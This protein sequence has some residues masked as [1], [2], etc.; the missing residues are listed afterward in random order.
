MAIDPNTVWEVRTG[1]AQSN[2]A[3]FRWV[4]LVNATYRWILSAAGVNEY[5]CELAAGGDPTLV[6]PGSLMLDGKFNLA[7]EGV[8]G[9]LA[10][11][12]WGYGNNDGLAFNTVY[13]RLAD[14]QD[15]DGKIAR[16]Q[17]GYVSVGF[18]G[19]IDYSQQNAAQLSV[20]DIATDGAGTQLTS[21]T[22]G[23]TAAMVGNVIYLTGGG[24]T[25]E[26][27]QIAT[28][29]DANN[30]TIDRSAGPNLLGVTGK[31]GGAFAFGG[32]LDD[33]FGNNGKPPGN[34]FYIGPGTHNSGDYMNWNVTGDSSLLVRIFGYH[35]QRGDLPLGD[36]RPLVNLGAFLAGLSGGY[37]FVAHL[38]FTAAGAYTFQILPGNSV[39]FNCKATNTRAAADSHA[40]WGN[41]TLCNFI[42]CQA[43]C[44]AQTAT[45]KAFYVGNQ[46]NWFIGCYAK[47]AGIGFDLASNFN[48]VLFCV[49]AECAIQAVK[50]Q[51]WCR[52]MGLTMY[53]CGDGIDSTHSL[54]V[55]N[56]IISACTRGIVAAATADSV[57]SL[58]NCLYNTTDFS[59][60]INHLGNIFGDP[61]LK[62]PAA[63]DFRVDGA[64]VNVYE[65]AAEASRF[66]DAKL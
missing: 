11:G 33:D 48:A 10:A 8:L 29:I 34:R 36:D 35:A 24:C 30:V 66:T 63:E 15:P 23:F 46:N 3:G 40:F 39:I 55:L 37:L 62:N 53:H 49:A 45:N 41:V 18:N 56:N 14:G 54:I 27:Y 9:A 65:Q 1:G 42:A 50:A 17:P 47:N 19:G 43:E 58:F 2:G 61:G 57:I 44:A 31:V 25:A 7:A 4:S 12:E 52:I 13:V 64:D 28:Y 6:H 38:R 60:Q 21:A 16:G 22:G 51:P 59:K 5:Y 20:I 26:W 32:A